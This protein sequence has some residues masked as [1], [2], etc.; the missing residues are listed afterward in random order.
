MNTL[1]NVCACTVKTAFEYVACVV[2]SQV[3]SSSA[4]TLR[5]RYGI[6]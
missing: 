4:V 2:I 6:H 5:T 1:R 3:G